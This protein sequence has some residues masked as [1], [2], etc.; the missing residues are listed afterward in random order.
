MEKELH[1]YLDRIVENPE[2]LAGK[3][4]VKDTRVS[5]ERVLAHL[6]ETPSI[7]DLF[8]AFPHLVIEDVQACLAYAHQSVV[9]EREQR[10]SRQTTRV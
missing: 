1:H 3:P 6:A 9:N 5:V 8:A 10:I 4:V 2:I 7:D